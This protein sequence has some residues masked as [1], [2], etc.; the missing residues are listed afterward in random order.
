MD[1]ISP[2]KHIDAPS[3]KYRYKEPRSRDRDEGWDECP[4]GIGDA[5]S[6]LFMGDA[7]YP[8]CP[9]SEEAHRLFF[10]LCERCARERTFSRKRSSILLRNI[11]S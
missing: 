9:L 10:V 8:S 11:A 6:Y 1:E 2:T 4:I 5:Y 3:K 7:Y